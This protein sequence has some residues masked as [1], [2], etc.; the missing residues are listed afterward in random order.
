VASRKR[1]SPATSPL[2]LARRHLNWTLAQLVREIDARSPEPTGVTES[3]ASAWETGRIRTSTRYRAI[4]CEIYQQPPETLFAHQ[5]DPAPVLQLVG[6]QEPQSGLHELRLVTSPEELLAEMLQVV[7][8]ARQYLVVTGSRSRDRAYLS[9]IER[10]LQEW[11]RLVHY[12]L[13]FGP[14]HHQVLKDHLLRLLAVRDPESRTEGRKT[15]YLGI[16]D[17]LRQ[18]P[19]R[20][21]CASEHR[22]VATLPSLTTA[23]NFDCGVVLLDSQ[24]AIG[25]VQHGKQLY[26][27]TRKLE[28]AEAVEALPV[29]R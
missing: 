26:P 18:D 15:L 3:L 8:G 27:G 14:P 7:H 23:G 19:E 13:L 17:D 16:V 10:T 11:P 6:G 29:L 12:R 9:D 1:L 24:D 21:F 20:F 28:T 4:L 25:L 22:A 2:R 5:D